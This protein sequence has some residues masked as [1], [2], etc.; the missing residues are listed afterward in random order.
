MIP[1]QN[2]FAKGSQQ[3]NYIVV[4][5]KVDTIDWLVLPIGVRLIDIGTDVGIESDWSYSFFSAF[6][7]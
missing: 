5:D 6:T 7:I 1:F 3:I 2:T 4:M